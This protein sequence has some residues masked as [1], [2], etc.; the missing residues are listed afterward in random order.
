MLLP[1]RLAVVVALAGHALACTSPPPSSPDGGLGDAPAPTPDAPAGPARL[2]VAG[3][4]G[5]L[6]LVAPVT[7]C[8]DTT[9]RGSCSALVDAPSFEELGAYS[10]CDAAALAAGGVT[11]VRLEPPIV[12]DA[13]DCEGMTLRPRAGGD[14][15]IHFGRVARAVELA[16]N[17]LFSSATI[18]AA[19]VGGACTRSL[20]LEGVGAPIELHDVPAT[21]GT[22]TSG[23]LPAMRLTPMPGAACPELGRL[24]VASDFVG[25]ALDPCGGSAVPLGGCGDAIGAGFAGAAA[26]GGRIHFALFPTPYARICH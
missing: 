23:W 6:D 1:M 11:T 8:G 24:C 13:V 5:L 9:A 21:G 22:V 3:C 14:V 10:A 16:A 26:C 4:A 18:T 19:V 15:R 17:A 2:D 7:S 25:F 20:S 12:V